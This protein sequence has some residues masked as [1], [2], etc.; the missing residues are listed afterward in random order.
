MIG[1]MRHRI[2]VEVLTITQEP[3]G[4]ASE[5]WATEIS[6][7]ASVAPLKSS[8]IAIDGEV[9]ISD[10]Y[11]IIIRWANGRI[12]DKQRRIKYGDLILTISGV[13]VIDEAKRFF[14]ITCLT[15]G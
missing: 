4:G 6:T 15:N 2:T 10:G 14:Q 13:Q 11:K 7:W 12:M 5:T 3:G 9:K 1:K 8:R